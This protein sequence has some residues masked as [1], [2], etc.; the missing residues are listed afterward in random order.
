MMG[1]WDLAQAFWPP[2]AAN[3]VHAATSLLKLG[4][5]IGLYAMSDTASQPGTFIPK[6]GLIAGA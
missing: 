2:A 5:R 3:Q 6:F 4:E 1:D